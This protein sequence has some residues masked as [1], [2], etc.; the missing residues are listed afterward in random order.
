MA[1]T[2]G[3]ENVWKAGAEAVSACVAISDGLGVA[4]EHIS[5]KI[6]KLN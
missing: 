6:K 4:I 2:S 3:L 1:V 5:L